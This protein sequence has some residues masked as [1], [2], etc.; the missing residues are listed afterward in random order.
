[1]ASGA[2]FRAVKLPATTGVSCQFH[3]FGAIE[4]AYVSD[5]APDFACGHM[6]GCGHLSSRD[7]VFDHVVQS[8]IVFSAPQSRLIERRPSAA[9]SFDAVTE[10]ALADVNTFALRQL[11]DGQSHVAI[12]AWP[13]GRDR[14]REK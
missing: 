7:A 13:R 6:P 3:V 12:L 10:G 11:I 5:H 8:L 4:I 14:R 2:A 1:V 9:D